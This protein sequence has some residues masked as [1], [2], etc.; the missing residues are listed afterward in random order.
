MKKLFMSWWYSIFPTHIEEDVCFVTWDEA[1][2]RMK[3]DS[4]WV[5]SKE[6]DTNHMMGWV[7][8]CRRKPKT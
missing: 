2:K 3:A 6:E 7:W 4:T 5:L 8:I 1:D